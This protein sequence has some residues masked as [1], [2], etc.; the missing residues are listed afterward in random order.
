MAA[1]ITR[2]PTIT[3]ADVP[4][5]FPL[6]GDLWWSTVTG[7][8]SVWFDDGNSSQWVVS[9]WGVDGGPGPEGPPGPPGTSSVFIG[10]V[11]PD[12]PADNQLWWSSVSGQLYVWYNDGNTEQWVQVAPSALSVNTSIERSVTTLAALTAVITP[13]PKTI[14]SAC[15]ATVGD[16]GGGTWTFVTGDQSV[17]ISTN[18]PGHG[19]YAAP[20]SD[21]TGASGAWRRVFNG[22]M[23]L[24]WFGCKADGATDD[25]V[26]LANAFIAH[27]I[28]GGVVDGE[29][30]LYATSASHRMMYA[31]INLQNIKFKNL[32]HVTAQ[33]SVLRCDVGFS[34]FVGQI[35]GNTLTVVSYSLGPS[36]P[37]F[38][39]VQVGMRI[40]DFSGG[41]VVPCFVVSGAGLL[42]T[43]DGNPQTTA[44]G[45]ILEGFPL[46]DGLT[47]KNISVDRNNMLMSTA[48]TGQA[49]INIAGFNDV[50]L[51]DIEVFGDGCGKGI[52]VANSTRVNVIRPY[53]HDM[54][55]VL[56]A[57]AG[58]GGEQITGIFFANCGNVLLADHTIAHLEGFVENPPG[59]LTPQKGS[60]YVPVEGPPGTWTLTSTYQNT[61]GADCGGCWDVIFRNG[62]TIDVGEGVDCSGS[63]NVNV[64]LQGNSY[65]DCN[66]Y[67]EKT[68]SD[69]RKFTSMGARSYRA[70]YQGFV[71]AQGNGTFTGPTDITWDDAQAYDTGFYNAWPNV[72]AHPGIPAH[73]FLIAGFGAENDGITRLRLLD[74]KSFSTTEQYGIA[75]SNSGSYII[76]NF[77]AQGFTVAKY[78]EP[79]SP[80]GLI[81]EILHSPPGWKVSGEIRADDRII[82]VGIHSADFLSVDGETDLVGDVTIG[83]SP[84]RFAFFDQ[85][86]GAFSMFSLRLDDGT[87]A[88]PYTMANHS[89]GGVGNGVQQRVTLAKGAVAVGDF[90]SMFETV[91]TEDWSTAANKS[92][93]VNVKVAQDGAVVQSGTFDGAGV[94]S[95]LGIKGVGKTTASGL[96]YG[97]G[98]GAATVTQLTGKTT[99]VVSNGMCGRLVLASG[100]GGV[101]SIAAGA[102]VTFNFNNTATTAAD[103]IAVKQAD[104]AGS[105]FGAYAVY[106]KPTGAGT[107]QI[108]VRNLTAGALDE[109]VAI[110]FMVF[111]SSSS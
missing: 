68:S 96:G 61:D 53:V 67:S 59:T 86:A 103:Y 104:N 34:R 3:I 57:N 76:S 28:F 33:H 26:P 74:C 77:E 1:P 22:P 70:G 64:L 73:N 20:D 71:C 75:L 66:G 2:T 50:L 23:R 95:A 31:G 38:L 39:P 37:F 43:V 8:Q 46:H 4:P 55:W 24:R 21:P 35:V 14:E 15:R 25:A 111:R 60:A 72:P 48:S 12:P 92:A 63:M 58:S 81:T 29:N 109:P 84:S 90:A 108:V 94:S 45:D 18:D 83:S 100:G 54:A 11:P 40:T 36:P 62:Y 97:V 99:S 6:E 49:A 110:D 88:V 30:L 85:T 42:W 56:P 41:R 51:E 7:Q 9:N 98:A 52:Q 69:Q 65:Y 10:D 106:C 78:S 102:A 19:L 13:Y 105:T 5:G 80:N 44:A 27:G 16:G 91:A 89:I 17:N 107:N 79:V 93:A 82:G 47:M 101:N 32:D 87:M